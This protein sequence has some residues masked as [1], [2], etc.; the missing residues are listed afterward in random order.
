MIKRLLFTL[1]I[2]ALAIAYVVL[3]QTN[4][5]AEPTYTV[6]DQVGIIINT[7]D[8]SLLYDPMIEDETVYLDIDLLTNELGLDIIWDDSNRTAIMYDGEKIFRFYGDSSEISI[9]SKDIKKDDSM[10]IRSGQPFIAMDFI[11]D[12]SQYHCEYIQGTNRLIIDRQGLIIRQAQTIGDL[13]VRSG[14]SVWTGVKDIVKSGD[15]VYVY[16]QGEK[17]SFVRTNKG[18]YGYLKNEN[19]VFGEEIQYESTPTEISIPNEEKINMTWEYVYKTTPSTDKLKTVD[20]LDV[21]SPTWFHIIDEEGNFKDKASKEYVVWAHKNGYEVWG[22]FGNSFDPDLTNIIINDSR[23]REQTINNIIELSLKYNLDG[24]NIDFEHIY[25]KDKDMLSQFIKEL[26]PLAHDNNL[27]LSMDITVKSKSAN[28]SLCYDRKEIGKYVDYVALMAYDEYWAGGGVSGSVASLPWV[29]Y[30]ITS[31]LEEI[32]K[33]KVL[34]GVPFYAR[35]WKEEMVE[36]ELKVTSSAVSMNR[37]KELIEE[38]NGYIVWDGDSRQHYGEYTKGD[39]VYKVWLEDAA[40][41]R[42]R[43][44]LIKKY[45]LAGVASWRRGLEAEEIWSI[46]EENLR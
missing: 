7:V 32:P 42:E 8:R 3:Y 30:G 17:W 6:S 33:E 16:Q 1:M 21:I 37:A 4:L 23:L 40:S 26:S 22:L 10:I 44:Y 46:I 43:L 11:N 15:T 31:L 5:I 29:E 41:I 45:D 28:W 20:G 25:L 18:F 12:N 27:L 38:N 19:L 9:N 13:R 14:K 2:F 35:V 24:I 39:A 36:G 34:L